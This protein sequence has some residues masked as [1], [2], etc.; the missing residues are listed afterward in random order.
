M[1]IQELMIQALGP[2]ILQHNFIPQ[3]PRLEEAL[4]ERYS[5]F[6]SGQHDRVPPQPAELTKYVLR[7]LRYSLLSLT[8]GHPAAFRNDGFARERAAVCMRQFLLGIGGKPQTL[9]LDL[10]ALLISCM[11]NDKVTVR[12]GQDPL[13]S[14]LCVYLTGHVDALEVSSDPVEGAEDLE[15]ELL[16]TAV[17]AHELYRM[18]AGYDPLSSQKWPS[19]PD[20]SIDWSFQE[21]S[22]GDRG[23]LDLNRP[24]LVNDLEVCLARLHTLQREIARR[25]VAA[26]AGSHDR[27][28]AFWTNAF[29]FP[30]NFVPAQIPRP[31]AWGVEVD[32]AQGLSHRSHS[33]RERALKVREAEVAHQFETCKA[34]LQRYLIT[35]GLR[36]EFVRNHLNPD[37]QPSDQEELVIFSEFLPLSFPLL[38][39]P[40]SA[41]SP[42]TPSEADTEPNRWPRPGDKD[43][44]ARLVELREALANQGEQAAFDFQVGLQS[45]LLGFKNGDIRIEVPDPVDYQAVFA[46]GFA[47][48]RGGDQDLAL[49]LQAWFRKRGQLLRLE[50]RYFRVRDDFESRRSDLESALRL[51]EATA[52]HYRI[53]QEL[54][55]FYKKESGAKGLFEI[56]RLETEARREFDGQIKVLLTHPQ[57]DAVMQAC[58]EILDG[59]ISLAE[60]KKLRPDAEEKDFNPYFDP[61]T[62]SVSGRRLKN[63]LSQNNYEEWVPPEID[64]SGLAG[65]LG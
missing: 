52:G 47:F 23:H 34:A 11:G 62:M 19:W 8:W 33:L 26:L 4:R 20:Q 17:Q 25:E 10:G 59:R 7:D 39:S 37:H 28:V 3:V 24:A 18:M 42:G 58:V 22:Q 14:N 16:L 6:V 45:V 46:E 63:A 30:E 50:R 43:C 54:I 38:A 49:R 27:Q 64:W 32:R 15:P 60:L 13:L 1:I 57:R 40:P 9:G 21:R 51:V 36:V 53:Y 44:E 31:D 12:A 5:H 35:F 56:R 2:G 48:I 65:G 29:D 61:L 55:R 41:S